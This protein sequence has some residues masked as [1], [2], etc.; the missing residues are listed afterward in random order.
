MRTFAPPEPA[1][2]L[3]DAQMCGSFYLYMYLP[4]EPNLPLRCF[5]L[6][7]LSPILSE[8]EVTICD[9]QIWNSVFDS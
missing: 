7:E 8:L 3:H 9:F 1:K 6:V 4:A 5:L 2:P